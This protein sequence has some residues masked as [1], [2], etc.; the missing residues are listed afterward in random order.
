MPIQ[1]GQVNAQDSSNAPKVYGLRH[2]IARCPGAAVECG[3]KMRH[4][5]VR[6]FTGK[7]MIGD[8]HL[9]D[10]EIII[11]KLVDSNIS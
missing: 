5:K 7:F 6:K 2:G 1:H 9:K 4:L 11:L 3:F 8:Y 10:L